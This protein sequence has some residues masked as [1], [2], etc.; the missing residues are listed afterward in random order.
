MPK[1][2]PTG[3]CLAKFDEFGQAPG[4]YSMEA[5]D[6]A[7]ILLAGI[8]SGAVTRDALLN[9][10]TNYDGQGLARQYKW[11]DKGELNSNMIW[12]YKVQ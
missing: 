10:V 9:F 3:V 8:D 2:I 4:T 5:Y 12:I 11:N 7:T 1:Q 6:A